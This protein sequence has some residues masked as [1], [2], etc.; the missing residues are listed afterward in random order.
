MKHDTKKVHIKEAAIRSHKEIQ[1]NMLVC[2][3]KTA[4]Q[5][6]YIFIIILPNLLNYELCCEKLKILFPQI[7]FYKCV[8]KMLFPLLN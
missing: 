6:I 3:I 4:L 7:K 2:V 1:K 8:P 5:N